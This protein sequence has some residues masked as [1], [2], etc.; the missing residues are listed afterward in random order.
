MKKIALILVLLFSIFL[1]SCIDESK[2]IEEL[3]RF[4]SEFE[5]QLID[6]GELEDDEDPMEGQD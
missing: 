1:S 2:K 4:E 6:K 3:N 5:T